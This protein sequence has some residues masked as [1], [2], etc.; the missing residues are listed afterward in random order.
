MI[1]SSLKPA[2]QNL[3]PDAAE[4]GD[5]WDFR[6]RTFLR[7]FFTYLAPLLLLTIYFFLH[8]SAMVSESRRLH[9]KAI[10][11]NQ[12][13]TLDLFLS[14]RLVNVANLI[15][16]PKFPFP[17]TS[18]TMQACLEKL[19]KS[20]GA[21]IDVGYFDSAGIQA[22]YAGP[23]PALEKRNY[24]SEAWFIALKNHPDKF[25][26][27]DI[28]LGFRAKPHFTIA[29]S[30]I[31][32][33]QHAVL[34]ATLDPGKIYEFIT[35]SIAGAQEV[36][37]SIVN[38]AGYYQ[39]A[40]SHIGTPLETS[41]FVPPENPRLGAQQVNITGKSFSYAYSWLR[42]AGWALIVQWPSTTHEGLF[43]R[44]PAARWRR[45]RNSSRSCDS[46]PTAWTPAFPSPPSTPPWTGGKTRAA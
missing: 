36:Y 4:R 16:D 30:R 26:I 40:T 31:I 17:P 5:Y 45:K 32:G 29:V 34:R 6:R 23:F 22:A 19:Q 38:R 7:L 44:V 41:S 14:E 18:V 13:N 42:N 9:L 8:Y 27:T 2:P 3:E 35:S 20:S 33:G 39:L 15:D 10:A 1:E 28:Y 43:S 12:A 24:S 11:E 21:F 37:T 46:I 25:I